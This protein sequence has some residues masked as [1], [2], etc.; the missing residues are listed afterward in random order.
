RRHTRL[1]SDWSSDVCS[2]DLGSID[3]VDLN[4]WAPPIPADFYVAIE[5]I[6]HVTQ[7]FTL[8]HRMFLQSRKGVAISTPNADEVDVLAMDSTHVR[9]VRPGELAELGYLVETIRMFTSDK[10]DTLVAHR[11]RY[12]VS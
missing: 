6:E 5:F 9:P 3:G 1:V 7:P 12:Q 2:S 4:R 8:L 10:R 11:P